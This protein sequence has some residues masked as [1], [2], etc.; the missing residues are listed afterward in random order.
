MVWCYPLCYMAVL[1]MLPLCQSCGC[2]LYVA[3]LSLSLSS[4][5]SHMLPPSLSMLPPSLCLV[6]VLFILPPPPSVLQLFSLCSPL[7][8]VLWPS[9]LCCPPPLCFGAVVFVLPPLLYGCYFYVAP[10]W[11]FSLCC[12]PP[13]SLSSGCSLYVAPPPPSL[14]LSLFLPA[15]L[16]CRP[17]N[18]HS[19][20]VR[21]K[22]LAKS[23]TLTPD[24]LFLVS[25]LILL[26]LL[27]L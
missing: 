9:S 10:P 26:T 25:S 24:P 2:S 18:S 1:F 14:S 23:H 22:L 21:L 6:T 17:L 8:R 27:Q 15:V 11:L 5:C 3:P 7:P 16:I 4:G 12:P 19:F 20:G 13:L